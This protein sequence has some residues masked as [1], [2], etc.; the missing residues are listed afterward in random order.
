MPRAFHDTVLRADT[1]PKSM[2]TFKGRA[3]EMLCQLFI[4]L[5]VRFFVAVVVALG[6]ISSAAWYVWTHRDS[7][8]AAIRFSFHQPTW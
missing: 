1:A 4:A 5:L 6:V 2:R 3:K 8:N 7:S